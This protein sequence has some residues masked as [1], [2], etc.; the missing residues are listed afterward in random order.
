MKHRPVNVHIGTVSVGS[1]VPVGRASL[2]ST[3]THH[4]SRTLS[5][6]GVSV[7]D[8]NG[9]VHIPEVRVRAHPGMGMD[10]LGE[11]VASEIHNQIRGLK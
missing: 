1:Q 4:L 7:D 10:S 5:A 8:S 2:T 6:G 9:P 3:I 11:C